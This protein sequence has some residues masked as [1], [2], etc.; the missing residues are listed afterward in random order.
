MFSR[1]KRIDDGKRMRHLK[2][3]T[4]AANSDIRF[5]A[6]DSDTRASVKRG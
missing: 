3:Y 4:S 5:D 1:L 6:C 2:S